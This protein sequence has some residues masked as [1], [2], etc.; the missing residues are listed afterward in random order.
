MIASMPLLSAMT[1]RLSATGRKPQPITERAV[2][3]GRP[4]IASTPSLT[5]TI[6]PLSAVCIKHPP[7]DRR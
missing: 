1:R 3:A 2:V 7:N 6:R 4:M 5:E